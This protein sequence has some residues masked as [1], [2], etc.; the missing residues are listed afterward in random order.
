MKPEDPDAVAV[1]ARLTRER[2]AA[3]RERDAMVEEAD[4]AR[5]R[6]VLLEEARSDARF[7]EERTADAADWMRKEK[8]RAEK[9]EATVKALAE[10]LQKARAIAYSNYG[11]VEEPSDHWEECR[12][13]DE[14]EHLYLVHT[15][16]EHKGRR[17]G[18]ALDRDTQQSVE[19]MECCDPDSERD[20]D[21]MLA[22]CDCHVKSLHELVT[23]A[24]AALAAAQEVRS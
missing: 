15:C 21:E 18:R 4:T 9:A 20:A 6:L 17:I 23:L 11:D 2:D 13:A 22:V 24:D 7:F 3:I 8:A 14:D 19:A 1:I 16:P 5:R 12:A 10:A